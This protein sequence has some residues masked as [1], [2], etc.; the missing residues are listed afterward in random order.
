MKIKSVFG[1]VLAIL[2]DV[3][4]IA[5]TA[6]ER[7]Y[8]NVAAFPDETHMRSTWYQRC[9]SVKSA[10]PLM[11]D[12]VRKDAIERLKNCSA[13]SSYYKALDIEIGKKADW[14]YVRHC[15][16]ATNDYG[17][18]MMLYANGKG[19]S[20][21]LRLATRYACSVESSVSEVEGR[22]AHL[23]SMGLKGNTDDFDLC[24]DITSGFM[25]GICAD[26]AERRHATVRDSQL[27]AMSAGWTT[28][29][30]KE[31]E[32]LK[33]AMREFARQR[34]NNEVDLSGTARRALQVNA[35]SDELDLFVK[36]IDELEK[37]RASR[38][39]SGEFVTVDRRLNDVFKTIMGASRSSMSEIG[40]IDKNG[41]RRTQR[42]WLAYRD[43]WT[44]FGTVAYPQFEP[45]AWKAM[46]TERR[47]DQLREFI[48]EQPSP[49]K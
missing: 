41:I 24:D 37:S 45:Q 18:L 33:E 46:M 8:P 16:L 36:D 20:K 29:K 48:D 42:A 15:A 31:F 38:T 44:V 3:S 32:K 13:M 30:K 26:I 28:S 23:A 21:D 9:L 34:A 1:L 22:V 12:L 35:E 7:G 14:D 6:T 47:L 5:S 19:V 2:I 49:V 10:E 25:Q 17:V 39:M 27:S 40:M 4:A 43:A 11:Q